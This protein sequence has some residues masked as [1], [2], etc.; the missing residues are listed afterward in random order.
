M[1]NIRAGKV[2]LSKYFFASSGDQLQ[3]A[4]YF[5]V[6]KKKNQPL[7]CPMNIS[8]HLQLPESSNVSLCTPVS[9]AMENINFIR[10]SKHQSRT[11]DYI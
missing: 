9:T 8:L 5:H 1:S 6:E 3:Q 10:I 11:K 2:S 7:K 4:K